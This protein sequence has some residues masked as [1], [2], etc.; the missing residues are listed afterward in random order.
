MPNPA[1]AA[2]LQ[3]NVRAALA[4][5]PKRTT[6]LAGLAVVMIV[7][8]VRALRGGPASAS[9]FVEPA[10]ASGVVETPLPFLPG[11][12]ASSNA[13]IDWLGQPKRGAKRNLFVMH[14]DHYSKDP[15]GPG[16]HPKMSESASSE[17][18]EKSAVAQA[19][20]N[21]EALLQKVTAG[22]TALKLQSTFLGPVPTALVNGQLVREGDTVADFLV[23][24]I[25]PRRIVVRQD[26]ITLRI[27]MD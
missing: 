7:L 22:A 10:V 6:L 25:A 16:A 15:L 20:Q 3:Q 2:N 18:S 17:E 24:S 12:V 11:P 1:T 8:W 9:A 26:G 27:S 14:A 13:L 21:R 23:M 19:D 5:D 4:A